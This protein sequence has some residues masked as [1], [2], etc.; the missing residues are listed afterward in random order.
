MEALQGVPL[1]LD[2]DPLAPDQSLLNVHIG[3]TQADSKNPDQM[4]GTRVQ[5]HKTCKKSGT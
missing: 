2:Q 4:S 3:G 5:V 1:T